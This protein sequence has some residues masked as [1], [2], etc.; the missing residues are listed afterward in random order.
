MLL[1]PRK[2]MSRQEASEKVYA[3]SVFQQTHLDAIED[4]LEGRIHAGKMGLF[5]GSIKT[6][7]NPLSETKPRKRMAIVDKHA[8]SASWQII[9]A[10]KSLWLG[11]F[12]PGSC[13]F[14]SFVFKSK[15]INF[16]SFLPLAL[17][18]YFFHKLPVV[19]GNV[20]EICNSHTSKVTSAVR[21]FL[22]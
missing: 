16:T 18:R 22:N 10:G 6:L 21:F 8:I 1:V 3:L 11:L 15:C 4:V 2:I 13:P 9:C 12:L 14:C 20:T 7:N 19:E 17:L 5:R